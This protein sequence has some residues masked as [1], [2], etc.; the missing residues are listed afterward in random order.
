MTF[1]CRKTKKIGKNFWQ[2]K[3]Y[4][5]TLRPKYKQTEHFPRS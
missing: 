3:K 4:L 2:N 5:L 1:E